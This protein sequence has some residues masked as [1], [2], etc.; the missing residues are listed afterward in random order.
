LG[1]KLV[2]NKL[3]WWTLR[4]FETGKDLAKMWV[5]YFKENFKIK[6]TPDIKQTCLK[7]PI[8]SEILFNSEW[9]PKKYISII[10][11]E[12]INITSNIIDENIK[13][14]GDPQW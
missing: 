3:N 4:S 11:N 8:N 1:K 14:I 12:Y 7:Q 5:K 2:Q 13:L 6:P 10:T 9:L